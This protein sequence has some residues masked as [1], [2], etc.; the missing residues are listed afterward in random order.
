MSR[1]DDKLWCVSDGN[2]ICKLLLCTKPA[3]AGALAKPSRTRG[4]GGSGRKCCDLGLKVAEARLGKNRLTAAE[5]FA[6]CGNVGLT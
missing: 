5:M 2:L 3:M 1:A 6:P 4:L